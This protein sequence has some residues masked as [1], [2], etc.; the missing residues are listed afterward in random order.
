MS[1]KASYQPHSSPCMYHN[2]ERSQTC[3]FVFQENRR[4]RENDVTAVEVTWQPQNM[5]TDVACFDMDR[6]EL[7]YKTSG[8][9]DWQSADA[10]MRSAG[11]ASKWTLKGVKPCLQYEFAIKVSEWTSQSH[12]LSHEQ[13]LRKYFC[14]AI[15]RLLDQLIF[16]PV[17]L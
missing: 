10:R 5:L 6:T 13:E 9:A 16:L 17:G 4:S 15:L 2:K 11:Q 14:L 7:L 12:D 1:T 3:R 8:S